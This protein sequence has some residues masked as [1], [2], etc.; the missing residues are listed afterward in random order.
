MNDL[1]YPF[2]GDYKLDRKLN[3]GHSGVSKVA[4]TSLHLRVTGSNLVLE[5]IHSHQ[6]QSLSCELG[7]GNL[8]PRS[9]VLPEGQRAFP[10]LNDGKDYHII[11]TVLGQQAKHYCKLT[12]CS[13]DDGSARY[14]APVPHAE[15]KHLQL[16]AVQ[17]SDDNCYVTIGN[18]RSR[19]P[20]QELTNV[21]LDSTGSVYLH[22]PRHSSPAGPI[23]TLSSTPHLQ[24]LPDVDVRVSA[25]PPAI[26]VAC[27]NHAVEITVDYRSL[28]GIGQCQAPL[29]PRR[30]VSAMIRVSDPATGL[31]VFRQTLAIP[32]LEASPAV[33]RI[34]DTPQGRNIFCTTGSSVSV[35]NGPPVAGEQ[36]VALDA[37]SHAVLI[38][39]RSLDGSSSA[40]QLHLTAKSVDSFIS[41]LARALDGQLNDVLRQVAN[42]RPS[43]EEQRKI[44]S[45]I[46]Q[47]LGRTTP[48]FE[49]ISSAT[50]ISNMR[51]DGFTL[52]ASH[53]S[54]PPCVVAQGSSIMYHATDPVVLTAID[55][56]NGTAAGICKI[57]TLMAA[58]PEEALVQKLLDCAIT[59]HPDRIRLADELSR[60]RTDSLPGTRLLPLLIDLLRS[61]AGAQQPVNIV[62]PAL[63]PAQQRTIT[64]NPRVGEGAS[65]S[66][67]FDQGPPIALDRPTVVP[68]QAQQL[69]LIPAATSDFIPSLLRQEQ[70]SSPA[71]LRDR[72]AAVQPSTEPERKLLN[73]LLR[74]LKDQDDGK[75]SLTILPTAKIQFSSADGCLSN[76][77]CDGMQLFAAVDEMPAI[78]LGQGSSVPQSGTFSEG[79]THNV[80]IFA[81]DTLGN[82]RAESFVAVC[83]PYRKRIGVSFLDVSLV[84][85]PSTDTTVRVTCPPQYVLNIEVDQSG[86]ADYNSYEATL[87][88]DAAAAHVLAITVVDE[89]GAPQFRQ[90]FSVPRIRAAPWD[91]A[92]DGSAEII[93][94]QQHGIVVTASADRSPERVV[95]GPL[96]LDADST[97]QLV[98]RKFIAASSLPCGGD[99]LLSIPVMIDANDIMSLI[100]IFQGCGDDRSS[101]Y[102]SDQLMHVHAKTRSS[103]MKRLITY[104]VQLSLDLMSAGQW[105]E[106]FDSVTRAIR[107]TRSQASTTVFF[108]LKGDEEHSSA[109]RR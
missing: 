100:R 106:Y 102:V 92:V 24:S 18:E 8:K 71:G 87:K 79:T 52:A 98:L 94:H 103:L 49:F 14:V 51:C 99:L 42:I 67:A 108:R 54:S 97:H 16:M 7:V 9:V 57:S 3:H 78:A 91:V 53:G 10:V 107:D 85:S 20:L 89:T 21:R 58:N 104:L 32:A 82:L 45:H 5:D 46:A 31:T 35:D 36:G 40:A 73:L 37:Q 23:P 83:T 74:L 27:P 2:R 76:I 105:R 86:G 68:P 29:D 25:D 66:V 96:R 56:S 109:M 77:R 61:G 50:N 88:M 72:W 75:T 34:D 12:L 55:P 64:L 62:Q 80:R 13:T 70:A 48:K 65:V 11:A 90:K 15:A 59:S 1:S 84:P 26:V 41:D 101:P 39:Q 33:A 28:S 17:G 69:F 43:N 60:V 19:L 81:K 95:D 4:P 47:G 63:P 38:R 30:A 93:I 6:N 22:L 44:L